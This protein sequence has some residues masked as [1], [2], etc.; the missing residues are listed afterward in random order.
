MVDEHKSFY[1]TP[2]RMVSTLADP[3][4]AVLACIVCLMGTIWALIEGSID[5]DSSLIAIGKAMMF[6]L[7]SFCVSGFVAWSVHAITHHMVI[8][9]QD[10]HPESIYEAI[11]MGPWTPRRICGAIIMPFYWCH[12]MHHHPD[13]TVSSR[14]GAQ[15][16]ET[17]A[18]GFAGGAYTIFFAALAPT[19]LHL[20]SAIAFF[21][22]YVSVHLVNFH[23]KWT[24]IHTFHHQDPNKD[25][26]PNICD[27]L[28]HTTDRVEDVWHQIP[29]A[30]LGC[31]VAILVVYL[32]NI[33]A[34][35]RMPMHFNQRY[36]AS[37]GL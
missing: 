1:S 10:R 36:V 11:T 37:I 16:A 27:I 22:V 19:V 35:K 6:A 18:T 15:I 7:G 5:M 26:S 29:N 21:V 20:G 25:L 2:D 34:F 9:E 13:V 32:L 17:V 14:T 24:D 33:R 8:S 4:Y 12:S 30:L 31:L 28:F 3:A 23:Y